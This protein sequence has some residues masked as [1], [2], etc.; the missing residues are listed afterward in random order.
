MHNDLAAT[1]GG[2][3]VFVE[4]AINIDAYAAKR[5]ERDLIEKWLWWSER[6]V[7]AALKC[8][9]AGRRGMPERGHEC[10]REQRRAASTADGKVIIA[11]RDLSGNEGQFRAADFCAFDLGMANRSR[12][13]HASQVLPH[14]TRLAA[15]RTNVIHAKR[16]ARDHG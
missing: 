6:I 2:E 14:Q 9:C 12:S 5:G 3:A 10:L 8:E 7:R 4:L 11:G 13:F 1:C 16:L 15:F